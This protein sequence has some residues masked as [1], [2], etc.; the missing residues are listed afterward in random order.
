MFLKALNRVT[1]LPLWAH[2]AAAVA[3]VAGFQWIKG[4]LDASYAASRHPV[5]YA[6]GQTAFSGERIKGWYAQMQNT[7]TL[8]VYWT[9]QVIDYG[10]ILAMACMGLF[11]CTFL[12][13]FSRSGSWGRRIGLLAGGAVVLGAVCDAIENAWSFVML[14]DPAGFANWLAVP[15]SGFASLKFAL[16]ALGM[17]ATIGGLAAGA[18]GHMLKKPQIG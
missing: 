18:V 1:S 8:D 16:I 15:Y 11:V 3:T 10:F 5:D 14:A 2:A 6:V 13:R 12:A 9:T 17:V 4:R 7:G